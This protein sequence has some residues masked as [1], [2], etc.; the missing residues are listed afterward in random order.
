MGAA[1]FGGSFAPIVPVV[2][3]PNTML[4]VGIPD[5]K[6]HFPQA[7]NSDCVWL[8]PLPIKHKC[9]MG[10]PEGK[11]EIPNVFGL[12]L[13]PERAMALY[14]DPGNGKCIQHSRIFHTFAW[15]KI[16][17]RKALPHYAVLPLLFSSVHA[18]IQIPWFTP[19]PCRGV[20]NSNHQEEAYENPAAYL[21]R[22]LC[23]PAH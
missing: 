1:V 9:F 8:P 19:R 2:E 11:R 20:K 6:L 23:Q 22:S 21:L 15:I 3:A 18:K 17:C 14:G 5:T 16:S 10:S 7:E 13:S 4:L 12:L